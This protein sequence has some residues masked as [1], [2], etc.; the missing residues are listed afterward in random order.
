MW[1]PNMTAKC[2]I[3]DDL[4]KLPDNSDAERLKQ[5]TED[6]IEKTAKADSDSQPCTEEQLKQLKHLKRKVVLGDKKL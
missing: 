3:L 2:Y 4:N 6:D 5:M 1:Y